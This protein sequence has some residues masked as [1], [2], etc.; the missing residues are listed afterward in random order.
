MFSS[1]FDSND[2][3]YNSSLYSSHISSTDYNIRTHLDNIKNKFALKEMDFENEFFNNNSLCNEDYSDMVFSSIFEPKSD[4][5]SLDEENEPKFIF[6]G[7]NK[8]ENKIR[9]K[10]EELNSLNENKETD[11]IVPS[12]NAFKEEKKY[13]KL[14]FNVVYPKS[15]S[16]FTKSNNNK[17]IYKEKINLFKLKK[18]E[19]SL[20]KK[21]HIRKRRRE[22]KDNIRKK[23]KRGFLNSSIIKNLN[24][25]LISIG[26]RFFFEKFPQNF[27]S[28][29][30]KQTNKKLLDLTLNE[31]FVKK[32]LYNKKDY[33]H[34][35]HNLKVVN[36]DEIKNNFMLRKI[37]DMKYCQLFKDYINSDEFKI[38]EINRL[39]KKGMNDNYINRYIM[40]SK[41]FIEFFLD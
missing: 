14:I 20:K 10:T 17:N 15:F 37:L 28:D 13:D 23:I 4:L 18:P 33:S 8:E 40:L 29:V 26:S 32:E 7:E 11:N 22:N 3:M 31:I 25:I 30:V 41:N 38:D 36:D 35:Y 34:Y 19:T 5:I 12:N 24:D 16:L 27:V 9:E 1:G 2:S 6:F 21:T 39:K